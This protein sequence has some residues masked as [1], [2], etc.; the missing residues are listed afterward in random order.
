MLS[1]L[2]HICILFYLSIC[3]IDLTNF[4]FIPAVA[5]PSALVLSAEHRKLF[6]STLVMLITGQS[7]RQG[8]TDA[9]IIF[10]ILNLM[11]GWLLAPKQTFLTYKELLVLLQRLAQ[12][13]RLHAIPMSLKQA[14]DENFLDLLHTVITTKKVLCL[15]Q[16]KQRCFGFVQFLTRVICMTCRRRPLAKRCSCGWS[17]P[18]AAVCR[19]RTL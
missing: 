17:A 16:A 18:S 12:I 8:Q 6:L 4:L 14:W 11:R 9:G 5:V 1:Q 19:V 10:A 2:W 15:V 13:D 3:T 7:V